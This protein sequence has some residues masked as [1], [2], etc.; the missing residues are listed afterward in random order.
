MAKAIELKIKVVIFDSSSARSLGQ[1]TKRLSR[2][3]GTS[4][5]C[6]FFAF[7]SLGSLT[8]TKQGFHGSPRLCWLQ[9]PNLRN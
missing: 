4:Q 6:L 1:R 3:S 5:C 7:S 9:S 2:R 8:P